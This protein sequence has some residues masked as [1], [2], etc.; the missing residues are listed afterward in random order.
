[1]TNNPVGE[2]ILSV[3]LNSLWST[4]IFDVHRGLD[5]RKPL[6]GFW[7]VF[8]YGLLFLGAYN[9]PVRMAYFFPGET[10][11]VAVFLISTVIQVVCLLLGYCFDRILKRFWQYR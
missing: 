5:A 1:M 4:L 3:F 6:S 10:P 9:I 8:V 2:L 11:V 7:F